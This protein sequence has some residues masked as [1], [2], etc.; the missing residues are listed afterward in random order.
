MTP[1]RRYI[2]SDRYYAIDVLECPIHIIMTAASMGAINVTIENF[3][4]HRNPEA[5]SV[6]IN[7][8]AQMLHPPVKNLQM[9]FQLT[10]TA[11]ISLEHLWDSQGCYAVFHEAP[12]VKFRM[13]D[14]DE[15]R[16]YRALD[17]FKWNLELAIPDSASDGWG[18]ITS[19]NKEI[20]D[21]I[22]RQLQDSRE[23][24]ETFM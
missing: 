15:N 1:H 16:R 9:D 8:A 4:N 21:T 19:P 6:T 13:S 5:V 20:I 18:R 17:N 14:L 12:E 2:L 11:F 23:A 10:K 3:R 22:E 7:Y 24:P